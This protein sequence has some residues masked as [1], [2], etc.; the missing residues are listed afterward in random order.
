MEQAHITAV[1]NPNIRGRKVI[2]TL[3]VAVSSRN[4]QRTILF[5]TKQKILKFWSRVHVRP[6][7]F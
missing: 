1:S 6:A 4:T 7:F 5:N 3:L 2:F